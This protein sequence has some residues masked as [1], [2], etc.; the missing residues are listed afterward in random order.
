MFIGEAGDRGNSESADKAVFTF[1]DIRKRSLAVEESGAKKS[2]LMLTSEQK[3][4]T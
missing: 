2:K 3:W 4:S 1:N